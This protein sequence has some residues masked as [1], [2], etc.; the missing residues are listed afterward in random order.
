MWAFHGLSS[1]NFLTYIQV[2][3]HK[4]MMKSMVKQY[5]KKKGKSVYY[6]M[7]NKR[8]GMARKRR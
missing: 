7:E 1:F 6:A 4:K 3:V 8:K 5:G 2:P